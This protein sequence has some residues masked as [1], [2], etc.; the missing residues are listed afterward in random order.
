MGTSLIEDNWDKESMWDEVQKNI[1]SASGAPMTRKCM[2][3]WGDRLCL[4]QF[5]G[6]LD[7]NK[8][9]CAPSAGS[10]F[11]MPVAAAA[12]EDYDD[13]DDYDDDE[14]YDEDAYDYARYMDM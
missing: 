7:S 6:W 2:H 10:T 13:Y 9:R 5:L 1:V 8:Y 4:C 11:P 12:Y 3:M 14:E